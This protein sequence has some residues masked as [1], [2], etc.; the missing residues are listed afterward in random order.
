MPLTPLDVH[1]EVT[2]TGLGWALRNLIWVADA[3]T[4]MAVTKG[5]SYVT[6]WGQR[7]TTQTETGEV[8][9]TT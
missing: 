5:H 9:S 7:K 6:V 3:T 1:S 4:A 2:E 8:T